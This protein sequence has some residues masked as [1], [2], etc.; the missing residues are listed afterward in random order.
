MKLH[1][2]FFQRDFLSL[3]EPSMERKYAKY[4]EFQSILTQKYDFKRNFL[5][6]RLIPP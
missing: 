4:V 2:G 5:H 6:D 1:L 3:N